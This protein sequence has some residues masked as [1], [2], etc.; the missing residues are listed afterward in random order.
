VRESARTKATRLLVEGRVV[1][2]LVHP[3]E[4]TA[5]V[6]GEG[7]IYAAGWRPE[8]GWFCDCEARRDCSHILSLKRIVAVDLEPRR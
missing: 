8:T 5:R 4:V 6:R 2:E 7:R 1:V 3:G